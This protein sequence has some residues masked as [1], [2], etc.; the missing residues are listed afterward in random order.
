MLEIKKLNFSYGD[1]KVL[2]DIDIDLVVRDG[3]IVSVAGGNGAGKSTTRKN[4]SRLSTPLRAMMS[5]DGTG[6]E[7]ARRTH[8]K[9]CL[10]RRRAAFPIATSHF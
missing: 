1:L 10:A 5:F 8:E 3:E 2:W 9:A 4:I 7:K 6:L